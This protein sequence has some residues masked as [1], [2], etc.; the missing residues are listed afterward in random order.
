MKKPIKNQAHDPAQIHATIASADQRDGRIRAVVENIVPSLNGGRFPV[1]RIYGDTMVVEADC[2]A[3]GHDVVAC[4]LKWR[5][6]EAA[7][8]SSVPMVALGNDRWRASFDID[9]LGIWQYTV[10]ARVDPFLSWRHDF[11]RRID[12]DDVRVAALSGAML[13][14][15]AAHRASGR[16]HGLHADCGTEP[17]RRADH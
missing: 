9:A 5:T 15:E 3:D 12:V 6:A 13:I 14:A 1:K 8:W 2:F 4:N 16:R 7:K 11:A 17:V 10:Q